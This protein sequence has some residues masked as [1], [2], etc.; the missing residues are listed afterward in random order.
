[1]LLTEIIQNHKKKTQFGVLFNIRDGEFHIFRWPD[2]KHYL[3]AQTI[4]LEKLISNAIQQYDLT[5]EDVLNKFYQ[6]LNKFSEVHDGEN[7]D[8]EIYGPFERISDLM[9]I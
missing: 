1:M 4:N 7:E 5:W 9:I 8:D 2:P 3:S 6:N